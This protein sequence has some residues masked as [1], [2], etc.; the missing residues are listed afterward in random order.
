M[1]IGVLHEPFNASHTNVIATA[2]AK[3]LDLDGSNHGSAGSRSTCSSHDRADGSTHSSHGRA[4]GSNYSTQAPANGSAYSSD[5]S[6]GASP[7]KSGG[8]GQV[9]TWSERSK[10]TSAEEEA[11]VKEVLVVDEVSL[12]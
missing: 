11:F 12:H 4:D 7:T 8:F 9:R 10:S 5:D 1:Q 3:D 6:Y 2:Q